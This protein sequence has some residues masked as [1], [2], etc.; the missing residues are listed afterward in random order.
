MTPTPNDIYNMAQRHDITHNGI[1]QLQHHGMRWHHMTPHGTAAARLHTTSTRATSTILTIMNTV[2]RPQLWLA[3]GV[4]ATSFIACVARLAPGLHRTWTNEIR[5]QQRN[6]L[7]HVIVL[8][9]V[10]EG[11]IG[12]EAV[13]V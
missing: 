7:D 4:G 3:D 10:I 13:L 6:V 11:L 12:R 9:Y 2:M 1:G 5:V 8:V